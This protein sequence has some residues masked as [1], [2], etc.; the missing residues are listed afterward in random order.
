MNDEELDSADEALNPSG[1]RC[2][3]CGEVARGAAYIGADRYCHPDNPARPDCYT[4]TCH[5]DI[6]LE[7]TAS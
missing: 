1:V 3:R 7:G 5:E 2:A 4:L 6:D